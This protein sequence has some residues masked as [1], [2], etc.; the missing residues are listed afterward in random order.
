MKAWR[1]LNQLELFLQNGETQKS[2][3]KGFDWA[4]RSSLV[5]LGAK[6][7]DEKNPPPEVVQLL[8]RLPKFDRKLFGIRMKGLK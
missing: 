3:E 8:F 7:K 6:F 1:Q 4:V 5:I 2:R